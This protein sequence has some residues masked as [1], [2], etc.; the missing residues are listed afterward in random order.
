MEGKKDIQLDAQIKEIQQKLSDSANPLEHPELKELTEALI[1]YFVPDGRPRNDGWDS[2]V[3]LPPEFVAN[4]LISGLT[5][6]T[7]LLMINK[8]MDVT[9]SDDRGE[10]LKMII[11]ARFAGINNS[12]LAL[13]LVYSLWDKNKKISRDSRPGAKACKTLQRFIR[14]NKGVHLS[15]LRVKNT[16]DTFQIFVSSM[17]VAAIGD[18]KGLVHPLEPE[19]QLKV[20]GWSFKCVEPSPLPD[21]LKERII[22][23]VENCPV[24]LFD[25]LRDVIRDAPEDLKKQL[26]E[27]LPQIAE[28]NPAITTLPVPMEEQ[29]PVTPPVAPFDYRTA[30]DGLAAFIEKTVSENN[31]KLEELKASFEKDVAAKNREIDSLNESLGKKEIALENFRKKEA[32][33]EEDL[34]HKKAH[35]HKLEG[36][37]KEKAEEIQ[38]FEKKNNEL[39]RQLEEMS[40]TIEREREKHKNEAVILSQQIHSEAAY[41]VSEI[42]D[43]LASKLGNDYRDYLT[44]KERSST[45]SQ[46]MEIF[47]L[48]KIFSKL[49]SEGINC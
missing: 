42:R 20:L 29:L 18:E 12:N 14:E 15:N 46:S 17:I 10:T 43:R 28:N 27:K 35:I 44:I 21:Y 11:A 13:K 30:L 37:L 36:S 22:H 24:R 4:A 47:L 3:V 5:Q 2:L 41:K 38:S 33:V 40:A 1:K 31:N 25:R 23:A 19:L 9:K 8:I 6:E 34:S 26:S 32:R 48:E 45:E 49:K 16:M 7:Q 39:S